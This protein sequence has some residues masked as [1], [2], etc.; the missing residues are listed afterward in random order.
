[1]NPTSS[2]VWSRVFAVGAVAGVVMA[3]PGEANATDWQALLSNPPFGQVAA[4]ATAAAGELEFRG[5][6]QEDG[7]SYVNLFN[8][9]TKESQWVA[10]NGQKAG[11]AVKAYDAQ[12]EKVQVTQGGRSLTLPLKQAKVALAKAAVPPPAGETGENGEKEDR[13]TE[14]RNMIRSRIEA[15][16]GDPAQVMSNLPPEARAMMEEFRRRR[17]ERAE[18][19]EAAQVEKKSGSKS[20]KAESSS[21]TRRKADN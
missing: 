16:G 12:E 15:A 10:V 1:M 6:V 9:T 20:E 3:I 17:A 4:S 14:I 21:R 5:V 11:L 8:P 19:G 7:I 2:S 18:G 13:K